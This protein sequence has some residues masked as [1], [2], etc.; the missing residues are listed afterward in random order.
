MTVWNEEYI[1]NL[2]ETG[3]KYHNIKHFFKIKISHVYPQICTNN[4]VDVILKTV[5][6]MAKYEIEWEEW[7]N[8]AASHWQDGKITFWVYFGFGQA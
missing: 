4:L 1:F 8:K 2:G 5:K 7:R 3:Q 6:M